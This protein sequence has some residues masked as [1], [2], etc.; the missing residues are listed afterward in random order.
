[1]RLRDPKQRFVDGNCALD[2]RG[3]GIGSE[4]FPDR[5]VLGALV[6]SRSEEQGW[7]AAGQVLEKAYVCTV[8]PFGGVLDVG[9]VVGHGDAHAWAVLELVVPDALK[10]RGQELANAGQHVQVEK[11]VAVG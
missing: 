1:M 6:R 11:R 9:S 7:P 2:L 8:R 4:G 10:A 5:G 3:G